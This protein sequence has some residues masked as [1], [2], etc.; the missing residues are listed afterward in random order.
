MAIYIKISKE[1]LILPH[2]LQ[3]ILQ[4]DL[5]ILFALLPKADLHFFALFQY[6]RALALFGYPRAFPS[7]SAQQPQL[8]ISGQVRFNFLQLGLVFILLG[9]AS[10]QP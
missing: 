7:V 10:L 5:T 1:K 6:P 4:K 2:C 9:R 3:D 8:A